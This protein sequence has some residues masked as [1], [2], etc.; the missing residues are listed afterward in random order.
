MGGQG[1]CVIHNYSYAMGINLTSS[2]ANTLHVN[3]I[4][5]ANLPTTDPG[6]VGM[7]YRTGS[8]LDEVRVSI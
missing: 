3:C 5:V 4:N 8:S 1:N 7:L 6:I 2:A